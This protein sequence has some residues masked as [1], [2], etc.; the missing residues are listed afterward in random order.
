MTICSTHSPALPRNQKTAVIL[1]YLEDRSVS[2]IADILDCAP[3]TAK[4]H[5]HRGRQALA[6]RLGADT[7]EI[8]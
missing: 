8:S 3:S 7:R 4:V 6:K 1:H 5:L 2:Q